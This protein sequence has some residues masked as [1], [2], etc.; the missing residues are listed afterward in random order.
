MGLFKGARR[1]APPTEPTAAITGRAAQGQGHRRQ[2]SWVPSPCCVRVDLQPTTSGTTIGIT[3]S[4]VAQ[5]IPLFQVI[6][7]YWNCGSKFVHTQR[8]T[9]AS[10]MR[11]HI[12]AIITRLTPYRLRTVYS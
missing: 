6:C 2:V 7:L 9:A 11:Y 8:S 5:N 10:G 3:I 12:A 1:V 4:R